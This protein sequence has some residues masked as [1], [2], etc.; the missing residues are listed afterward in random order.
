MIDIVLPERGLHVLLAWHAGIEIISPTPA[1]GEGAAA[2]RAIL[3]ERGEGVYSVVY[4]VA[5]ID[6]SRRRLES[7]GALLVFEETVPPEVVRARGIVTAGQP[8]FTIRQAQFRDALGMDICL[9]ELTE[10]TARPPAV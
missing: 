3:E 9:Q 6:D 4:N 1:G 7:Q 5:S 10:E 2:V 8:S